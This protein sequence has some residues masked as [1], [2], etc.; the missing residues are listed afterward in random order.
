[1]TLII[2]ACAKQKLAVKAPARDLYTSPLFSLSWRW[3][4]ATEQ[5]IVVLSA[6]H[7]IVGTDDVLEPYDTFLGN[8]GRAE[9]ARL[10]DLV[11]QQLAP[12][13]TERMIVLGGKD[14]VSLVRRAVPNADVVEPMHGL[15]LGHRLR[16]LTATRGEQWHDAVQL[17]QMYAALR[18]QAGGP[19]TPQRLPSLAEVLEGSLPTRGIYFFFEDSEQRSGRTELRVTRVGT[20]A[21][22]RGA[23]S[24]LRSRLRTHA[25]TAALAGSHRS[26]IFRLHV[27]GALLLADPTRVPSWGNGS[28]G[29][30]DAATRASEAELERDVSRRL[31]EMRVVL[32]SVND[33]PSAQSDRAYIERNA[34]GL[35]STIGHRLDPPSPQWLGNSSRRAEIREHGMWNLDH[36]EYS[37]HPDFARVFGDYVRAHDQSPAPSRAPA[38]W[39]QARS[40]LF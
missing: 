28:G 16:W 17:E 39:W 10:T 19:L 21:V 20:H 22:S 8:L 40:T 6:K 2:V 18:E 7:G 33:E 34:I 36:L 29:T 14:Y 24:T 37:A 26:S 1:M 32:V 11:R 5:Q 38:G 27:G 12:H 3:A 35:V 13:A 15:S 23:A 4:E 25:G 30:A 9:V 31:R